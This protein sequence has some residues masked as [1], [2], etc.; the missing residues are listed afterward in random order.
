MDKFHSGSLYW[1]S[2]LIHG[3]F[4]KSDRILVGSLYLHPQSRVELLSLFL[5][6]VSREVRLCFVWTLNKIHL[7][8]IEPISVYAV[9][10]FI[11]TTIGTFW[12]LCSMNF[13]F[14]F[15]PPFPSPQHRPCSLHELF[16]VLFCFRRYCLA[17]P[18]T[19]HL[20]SSVLNLHFIPFLTLQP[21][22]PQPIYSSI[23]ACLLCHFSLSASI[24][25]S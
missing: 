24:N 21:I 7:L 6:L 11:A 14:L 12:L 13:D 17:L 8:L 18:T 3:P 10:T 15:L 23:I 4:I 2:F 5:I 19:K 16:Y 9:S 20:G 1:H 25:Y 22:F